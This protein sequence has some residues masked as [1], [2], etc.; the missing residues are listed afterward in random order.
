MVKLEEIQ[1]GWNQLVGAVQKQ[2]AQ[3]TKDDLSNIKGDINQLV[4]V[5]ERKT[6]QKREEIEQ[7]MKTLAGSTTAS[8]NRIADVASDYAG[9]AT[10]A[11]KEGYQRVAHATEDQ[12]RATQNQVRE[13]PVESLAIAFGIGI[14]AGLV[15]GASLFG[16]RHG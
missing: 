13:R 11:A 15:T 8:L 12:L 16:R 9:Y 3:I 10:E 14:V 1:G 5:I 7:F 2:Y 4:G 6:G